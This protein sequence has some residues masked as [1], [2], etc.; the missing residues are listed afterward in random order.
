MELDI[1]NFVVAY[2]CDD[3]GRRGIGKVAHEIGG[4]VYF[5]GGMAEGQDP[6]DKLKQ[7]PKL[8]DAFSL[9]HLLTAA[10]KAQEKTDKPVN[11]S[12]FTS[13]P[14]G[15]RNVVFSPGTAS[16]L[17]PAIKENT[18]EASNPPQSK[19]FIYDTEDFLPLL[20]YDHANKA[21]LDQTI[22][23]IIQLLDA[24]PLEPKSE[25]IFTLPNFFILEAR[26]YDL[27]PSLILWLRLAIEQQT[28][29]RKIRKNDNDIAQWL[30]TSRI[31]ISKY[32]KE[33]MNLGLLR[34]DTSV[35]PQRMSVLYYPKA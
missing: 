32:K 25:K 17:K 16:L 29:K 18:P 2:D 15:Q 9:N 24:R 35:R 4:T 20:T 31:T 33:L 30:Q 22:R 11:V 7:N 28:K 23:R 1:K 19:D 3:A 8:I 34:L 13:G 14:P 6:F 5:L 21:M 27:G 26:H 10:Q 12:F